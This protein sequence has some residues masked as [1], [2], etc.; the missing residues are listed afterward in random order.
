MQELHLRWAARCGWIGVVESSLPRI[1]VDVPEGVAIAPAHDLGV[2]VASTRLPPPDPDDPVVVMALSPA[3]LLT[4]RGRVSL[5]EAAAAASG[6]TLTVGLEAAVELD[7]DLL[8]A[9]GRTAADAGVAEVRLHVG[10]AAAGL[11][12]AD[13]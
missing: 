5:A 9:L 7:R 4:D 12:A 2:V 3:E 11:S 13:E 1:V 10:S 8:T 6:H